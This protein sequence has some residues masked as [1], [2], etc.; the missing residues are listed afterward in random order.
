MFRRNKNALFYVL[1]RARAHIALNKYIYRL[2]WKTFFFSFMLARIRTEEMQKKVCCRRILTTRVRFPQKHFRCISSTNL[3]ISY[4][5]VHI[6]SHFIQAQHEIYSTLYQI[7]QRCH[8]HRLPLRKEIL[9]YRQIEK[10]IIIRR[11]AFMTL[12]YMADLQRRLFN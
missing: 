4:G 3:L 7:Q 9:L 6:K 5:L 12:N 11:D 1:L 2:G 10:S 8:V